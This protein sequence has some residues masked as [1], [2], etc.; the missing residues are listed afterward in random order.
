MNKTFGDFNSFPHH[1]AQSLHFQQGVLF[2]TIKFQI[3]EVFDFFL[4]VSSTLRLIPIWMGMERNTK[5]K[6]TL[7]RST[8]RLSEKS[9]NVVKNCKLAYEN[10]ASTFSGHQTSIEWTWNLVRKNRAFFWNILTLQP[11]N[12][13]VEQFITFAHS[14]NGARRWPKN[15]WQML[16][17]L[18][19]FWSLIAAIKSS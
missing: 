18:F 9:E 7:A 3:Y 6:K 11:I 10:A 12:N 5:H 19:D 13:K 2:L 17:H 8:F 16:L 4:R 14:G 1:I 15:Q